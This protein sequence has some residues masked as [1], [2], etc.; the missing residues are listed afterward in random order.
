[1]PITG[2]NRLL[3]DTNVLVSGLLKPDGNER[4]V[5]RRAPLHNPPV[6]SGEH[7]RHIAGTCASEFV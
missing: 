1:M 6:D 7:R 3:V 2:V 5:L 4:R